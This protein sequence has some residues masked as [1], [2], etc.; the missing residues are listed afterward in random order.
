MAKKLVPQVPPMKD[1][2]VPRRTHLGMFHNAPLAPGLGTCSGGEEQL[3]DAKP[4]R[5][6]VGP[7]SDAGGGKK[8]I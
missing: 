4:K 3:P 2:R 8:V 7:A 1:P 6:A 5:S